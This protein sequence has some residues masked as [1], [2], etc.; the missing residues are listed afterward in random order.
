MAALAEWCCFFCK[1]STRFRGFR[2]KSLNN[3]ILLRKF[4]AFSYSIRAP[5]SEIW[6]HNQ[7]SNGKE[8]EVSEDVYYAYYRMERQERWQEEK[9][10]EHDVVSYDAMDNGETVGT[11]AIRDLEAPSIEELRLPGS[12]VSGCGTL[13]QLFPRLRG[14]WSRPFILR[15][16]PSVTM[17]NGLAWPTEGSTNSV[18]KSCRSWNCSWIL[19]E[20]FEVLFLTG[21]RNWISSEGAFWET[22]KC[23]R[24]LLVKWISRNWNTSVG[25]PC[26]DREWAATLEGA[27]RSTCADTCINAAL[28]V[29]SGSDWPES[30]SW[31]I[32][33][34]MT[35]PALVLLS[36]KGQL[37]EILGGVR[38]P[39]CA[40]RHSFRF[41][42]G[43]LSAIRAWGSSVRNTGKF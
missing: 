12:W 7:I 11:E 3:R 30:R 26:K 25:V 27:R 35:A 10:Q 4:T 8:I 40:A 1:F 38:F 31:P 41:C 9:K 23:P 43:W 5:P 34:G 24:L 2:R 18:K 20:V 39:W 15:I 29:G 14:S 28:K 36:R 19:W 32:C 33:L 37:G 22:G 13:W 16:F 17:Q 42:P 6:H 21:L